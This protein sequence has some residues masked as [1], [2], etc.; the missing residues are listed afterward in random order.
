MSSAL[1]FRGPMKTIII[2][3]NPH[4]VEVKALEAFQ[5]RFADF[6]GIWCDVSKIVVCCY[7]SLQ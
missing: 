2:F 6:F 1:G 4:F 7:L 3:C 5:Q